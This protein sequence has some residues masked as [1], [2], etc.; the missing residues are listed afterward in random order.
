MGGKQ[1]N[2]DLNQLVGNKRLSWFLNKEETKAAVVRK[3]KYRIYTGAFRTE[4]EARK[5]AE[6][7]GEKLGYKPFAKEKRI[8]TGVFNTMESATIAQQNI[9]RE[10][11][12]N[13]QIRQEQ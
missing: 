3:G 10:F 4:E 8:W 6:L 5:Q 11:G 7:I 12:F 2:V 9:N 1:G 13:A